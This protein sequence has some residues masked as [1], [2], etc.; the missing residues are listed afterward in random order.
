MYLKKKEEI[1]RV[2]FILLFIIIF[3]FSVYARDLFSFQ[4]NVDVN[5]TPVSSGGLVVEIWNGPDVAGSSLV[6]NSTDSFTSDGNIS[7]GKFD[8]VLG[9]VGDDLNLEYGKVYYMDLYIDDND[10]NFSGKERQVFM[11]SVGII[12]SSLLNSSNDYTINSL[13]IDNVSAVDY[14]LNISDGTTPRFLVSADGYVGIGTTGPGSKLTLWEGDFNVSNSDRGTM[15]YVQNSSGNVGIGTGNPESALEI[16]VVPSTITYY[17]NTQT[18]SDWNNPNNMVDGSISTPADSGG[19]VRTAPLNTNTCTGTNLGTITK[20]EERIYGSITS[21]ETIS[22]TD[23]GASWGE[24]EGWSTYYDITSSCDPCSWSDIQGLDATIVSTANMDEVNCAQVELRVTY[25]PQPTLLNVSYGYDYIKVNTTGIYIGNETLYVDKNN[26]G[27]GTTS[28]AGR[29]EVDT[30]ATD[31]T[32]V[33]GG[34]IINRG[35]NDGVGA[36]LALG[37]NTGTTQYGGIASYWSTP[38]SGI[39]TSLEAGGP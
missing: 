38:I 13:L 2:V 28:P 3:S 27:I 7:S 10:M 6:Y 21:F 11:S 4:G 16:V 1:N 29:L 36:R 20:V 34:F 24:T 35:V 19:D 18:G 22:D 14:Y 15:F 26:V 17:F 25:T 32:V 30:V 37:Y 33:T 23:S 5:G 9:S 12:N 31:D 39:K 8:I